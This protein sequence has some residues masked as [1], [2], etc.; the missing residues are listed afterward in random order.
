[1]S[2]TRPDINKFSLNYTPLKPEGNHEIEE[3]K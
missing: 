1:M 3:D 2:G